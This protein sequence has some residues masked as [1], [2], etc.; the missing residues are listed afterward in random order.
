MWSAHM[1]HLILIEEFKF[2]VQILNMSR[3]IL[4][5]RPIWDRLYY[6]RTL[7]NAHNPNLFLMTNVR[8]LIFCLLSK[9]KS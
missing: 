1:D 5:G 4:I 9:F 6:S 8:M 2:L 3:L 7:P